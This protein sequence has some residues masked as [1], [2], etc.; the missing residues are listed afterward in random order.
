MP[1]TPT[2]FALTNW[3]LNAGAIFC[4]AISAILI[5]ALGALGVAA[6]D[7][8]PNHLGIPAIM[9]GPV[10]GISRMEV[11]PIGAAALA[12]GLASLLLVLF[13]LLAA[14][15]IVKSAMNG[16]PFVEANAARLSRIG[17][18]LAVLIAV[19]FVTKL[20][21]D[22]MASRLADAHHIALDKLNVHFDGGSDFSPVG[23]LAV[24]L[25][26][27]LAQIFRHGSALRAELE[28]T[29]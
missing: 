9:P 11:L 21:V 17:W 24:L 7:L 3:L 14:A 15:G 16:D 20:A 28:G 10:G 29:V 4:L 22:G 27:V 23:I 25:I 12:G 26:F 8:T 18:F 5:I 19:Q 13:A 1:R 6:S 2:L